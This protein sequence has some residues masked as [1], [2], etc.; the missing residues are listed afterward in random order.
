MK[1]GTTI[2]LGLTL[3]LTLASC[4]IYGKK[5]FDKFAEKIEDIEDIT[6][7]SAK[8]KVVDKENDEK[9]EVNLVNSKTILGSTNWSQ[10]SDDGATAEQALAAL[11]VIAIKV[12]YFSSSE[13]EEATYYSGLFGGF[14]VTSDDTSYEFNKY[15]YLVKAVNEGKSKITIT[16]K[17]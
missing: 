17:K 15:G 5:D 10:A 8:V 1:K 6:Y 7:S 14:K 4:D 2:L 9:Y 13:I 16:Y 12:N 11:V 3:T